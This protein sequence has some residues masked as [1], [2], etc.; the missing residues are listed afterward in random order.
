MFASFSPLRKNTD[1]FEQSLRLTL[2]LYHFRGALMMP[3]GKRRTRPHTRVQRTT[4][5][6]EADRRSDE[7][8]ATL[9]HELRIPLACIVYAVHVCRHVR[10]EPARVQDEL[11]VIE[12]QVQH[13]ARLIEDLLEAS[14]SGWAE[15]PLRIERIEAGAL[16]RAA[17]EAIRAPLERRG[18]RL[19]ISLPTEPLYLSADPTRLLQA[20]INLLENAAKYT[21]KGGSIGV[22]AKRCET[23]IVVKIKDNGPGIPATVLPSIFEMYARG[24]RST[25]GLGIGLSVVRRVIELHGGTISVKTVPGQGAEFTIRIPVETAWAESCPDESCASES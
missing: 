23:H 18:H 25:R 7:A 21:E 16:L 5:L 3:S 4:A 14:S 11:C 6:R 19:T 17:A 1:C 15:T 24:E 8:A 12:R 20:L 9:A 22:C 10:N 2:A 13:M